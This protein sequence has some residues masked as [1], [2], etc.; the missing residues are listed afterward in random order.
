MQVFS[1]QIQCYILI[2][3][4]NKDNFEHN[5][6]LP[7]HTVNT[8]LYDIC[9]NSEIVGTKTLDKRFYIRLTL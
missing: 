8:F 5:F 4:S 3:N 1:S 7:F 9:R 2:H 6:P